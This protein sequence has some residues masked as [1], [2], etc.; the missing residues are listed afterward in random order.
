MRIR[1]TLPLLFLVAGGLAFA[2]VKGDDPAADLKKFEGSWVMVSGKT[3]GKPIPAD[4]VAKSRI[5][6][7]GADVVIETP[8]QAQDPIKAKA[9]M[10]AANGA[11]RAMNWTRANG[12][13]AGKTML[14][15][16]EFRG[17]DEYVV[18]FAPAGKERPKDFGAAAGSG[19]FHHVWKRVKG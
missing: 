13:D 3:D 14:A 6:W 8:H 1:H 4:Q 19:H 12:P 15:I 18:V 10:V 2:Q 17:P 7:R 5:T 11:T 9:T 16:Y